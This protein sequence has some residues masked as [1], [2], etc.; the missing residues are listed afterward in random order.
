MSFHSVGHLLAAAGHGGYVAV[1]GVS[2]QS[3]QQYNEESEK[4]FIT[5]N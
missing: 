1:F 2:D 4:V 3:I 5:F